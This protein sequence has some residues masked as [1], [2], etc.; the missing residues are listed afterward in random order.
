MHGRPQLLDTVPMP[1]GNLERLAALLSERN[2]IDAVL[3][4]VIGR[5]MTS[6]H[7]GEWIAARIFDIEL[8]PSASATAIDGRFRSGT[9]S[10]RT[11]NVKWY[12]KR[13]GLLDMTQADVLDHYLV[14]A[15]PRGPAASSRG[16]TRPW[17]IDSVHLF[18]ARALAA[19]LLVRGR[20]VGVASSV[21]NDA[22][23]AAEVYPRP[24]N[25]LLQLQ[26]EQ[27]EA[28]RLFARD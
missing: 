3:A 28:L 20:R 4:G 19:D 10:G 21:R 26:P 12:L 13:E 25:E 14:L 11:V 16:S 15:G 23:V 27:D 24:N 9:L 17:R 2:K 6:G 8:D 18:D 1:D 7:L 22:W 5:P